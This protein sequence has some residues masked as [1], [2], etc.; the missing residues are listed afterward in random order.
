MNGNF[1]CKHLNITVLLSVCLSVPC[2]HVRMLGFSFEPAPGNIPKKVM[3]ISLYRVIQF[4]I[5]HYGELHRA[6]TQ[7]K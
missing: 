7:F 3:P 2:S 5:S 6:K 1:V 4:V